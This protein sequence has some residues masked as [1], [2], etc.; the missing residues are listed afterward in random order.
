MAVPYPPD[1]RNGYSQ[2]KDHRVAVASRVIQ[3]ALDERPNWTTLSERIASDLRLSLRV[4]NERSTV[5]DTFL[6][7]ELDLEWTNVIVYENDY[8]RRP[9]RAD[10]PIAVSPDRLSDVADAV[11]A[12]GW[13]NPGRKQSR[14]VHECFV[15]LAGRYRHCDVYW[16]MHKYLKGNRLRVL[17]AHWMLQ[18]DVEAI[19]ADPTLT[20]IERAEI[21]TELERELVDAYVKWLARPVEREFRF[22]NGRQADLYDRQRSLIIEAKASH[23]DDVT[24]AHAMGQAMYYRSIDPRG[25]DAQIA[26]LLRGEPGEEASR[27]LRIYDVGLIYRQQ[28]GFVELLA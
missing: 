7:A 12:L 13:P 20:A 18:D 21:E 9:G 10:D 19:L 11:L 26:V 8:F 24:V 2:N 17:R 23:R 1:G 27:L 5:Q 3:A 4:P 28:D 15:E 25:L 22:A 16:A 6:A 14:T